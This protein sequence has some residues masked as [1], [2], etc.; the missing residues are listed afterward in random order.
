MYIILRYTYTQVG[1]FLW[2][3]ALQVNPDCDWCPPFGDMDWKSRICVFFWYYPWSRLHVFSGFASLILFGKEIL[4]END[5]HCKYMDSD[6]RLRKINCW[7]G[8]MPS[9]RQLCTHTHKHL[10]FPHTIHF[11]VSLTSIR[12]K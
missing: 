1:V 5:T 4:R 10:S 2:F 6:H 11:D 3:G 12:I 8:N 9:V 7:H